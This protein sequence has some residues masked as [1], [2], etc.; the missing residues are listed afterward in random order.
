MGGNQAAD[1]ESGG[2]LSPGYRV[3]PIKCSAQTFCIR[4]EFADG[5]ET[6]LTALSEYPARPPEI[7]ENH[8]ARATRAPRSP[9]KQTAG[10]EPATF[11]TTNP[12]RCR[13]RYVSLYIKVY[14]IDLVFDT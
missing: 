8:H 12:T 3:P 6:D 5:A 10:L 2:P 1:R 7:G 11:R 4:A 14:I 9:Q 13:L